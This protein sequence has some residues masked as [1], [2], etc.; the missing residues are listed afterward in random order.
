MKRRRHVTGFHASERIAAKRQ[1]VAA[2]VG[3]AEAGTGR[4]HHHRSGVGAANMPR[5]RHAAE[6]AVVADSQ[7]DCSPRTL[8]QGAAIGRVNIEAGECGRQIGRAVEDAVTLERSRD[9]QTDAAHLI[10]RQPVRFKVIG[11]S[12]D[13]AVNDRFRAGAGVGR[14]LQQSR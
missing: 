2:N 14:A 9:R 10:P 3:A 7:R 4:Q 13:P 8:G 12:L 11:D 1:T 6:V 5:L